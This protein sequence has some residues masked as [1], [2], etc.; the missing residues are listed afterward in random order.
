MIRF[1][2]DERSKTGKFIERESRLMV[3]KSLGRI[4]DG[5]K[6]SFWDDKMLL[7]LTVVMAA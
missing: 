5:D 2:L 1:H 3:A 7:K 6:V 4:A